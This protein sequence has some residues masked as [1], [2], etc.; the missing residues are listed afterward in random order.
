MKKLMVL[1]MVLMG[2]TTYARR[3]SAGDN[4][5][6]RLSI[7]EE[8]QEKYTEKMNRLNINKEKPEVTTQDLIHQTI[9]GDSSPN[10]RRD[11]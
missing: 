1:M 7:Y 11:G 8:V 9:D 5:Q 6:A 4:F 3:E 10:E 2:M